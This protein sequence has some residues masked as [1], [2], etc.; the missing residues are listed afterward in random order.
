[1]PVDMKR[2]IAITFAQMAK[3][4]PIDKITVKELVEQ[5]GISRQAFYYHFQD[6]LE[7]ME[8]CIRQMIR[9]VLENS[10]KAETPEKAIGEFVHVAVEQSDLL[11]RLLLS[12]RRA[13]V[14]RIFIDGMRSCI[15]QII[16]NKNPNLT[17]NY[18]DLEVTLNFYTYGMTGAIFEASRNGTVDE[19]YLTHKLYQLLLGTA[20]A[21]LR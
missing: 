8:W 5:C 6:L 17:M 11:M 20:A 16:Y 14:E 1:M 2:T 10:L 9:R 15:R 18:Q 13:Q 7:V 19:A 21:E 4:K 3:K 12:Q